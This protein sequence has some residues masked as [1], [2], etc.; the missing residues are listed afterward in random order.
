MVKSQGPGTPGMDFAQPCRSA[1][2]VG[3]Y[4]VQ[5]FHDLLFTFPQIP[6]AVSGVRGMG[7]LMKYHI[8]TGDGQLPARLSSLF[9]KVSGAGTRFD[10]QTWAV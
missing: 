4:P 1:E 2:G 9:I 6:I 7:F 5:L 8:E 3:N 10:P